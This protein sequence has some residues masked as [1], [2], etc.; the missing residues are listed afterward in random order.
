MTDRAVSPEDNTNAKIQVRVRS[1]DGNDVHFQIKLMS[2]MSKLKS[3]YCARFGHALGSVRFLYDGDRI[4]DETTAEVL[5]MED[6]DI[7]YLMTIG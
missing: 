2:P 7:I 6:G 4:T 1:A 5:G 3:A